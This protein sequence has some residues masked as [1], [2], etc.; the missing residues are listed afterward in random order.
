M[1]VALENSRSA[2]RSKRSL[3]PWIFVGG[4]AVVVVVNAVMI[5]LAVRSWTGL[6]VEKPY[7]RGVAYNRVLEAQHR[8]DALGWNFAVGTDGAD[9][10]RLTVTGRDGQ[11]LDGLALTAALVRPIDLLPDVPLIFKQTEAGVYVAEAQAPKPGQ[12]DLKVEAQRS[13]DHF[14]LVERVILK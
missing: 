8:Q 10:I 2:S 3:I 13:D 5:T 14:H 9:R 11:P 12:W 1:T 6:V 4:M 7:E